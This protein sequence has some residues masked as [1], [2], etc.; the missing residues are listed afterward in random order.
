MGT[1]F[2]TTGDM[3]LKSQPNREQPELLDALSKYGPKQQQASNLIVVSHPT[4]NQNVRQ[5]LR[6]LH[7]AGLLGEFHTSL[8]WNPEWPVNLILP[9]RLRSELNRRSYPH[10]PQERIIVRPLRESLRLLAGKLGVRELGGFSTPQVAYSLDRATAEAIRRTKPGAVYAYEGVA[11]ESF[12]EAKRQSAVCFYELPSGYWYYERDLLREEAELQ[13]DYA[14]TI[15]K[16]KDSQEHLEKK[17]EELATADHV[18]IPSSHIARTLQNAPIPKSRLHVVPYGCDE[19]GAPIRPAG[20]SKGSKLR[21]LFVGSLTQRKGLSYAIDAIKQLG[22]RVEFTLIGA[23]VGES[24]TLDR[25]LSEHRWIRSLPHE[26]VL[27]EMANS[28]VLL[29]PSLSEGFGLVISEALSRGVPVIATRNTGGEE[30][31]RDGCNGFLVATRSSEEIAARLEQ[32]DQDRDQLE[33][34]A[35]EALRR[36]RVMNWKRYRDLLASIITPLLR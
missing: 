34:M 31:I 18:F 11:L 9:D 33:E 36:S 1:L 17:D 24:R 28:D 16:L 7:E 25:A 26:G 14:D 21:L 32:L 5:V 29:L 30:V 4:G 15:P 3:Q 19:S 20:R 6:A 13:P 12:R 10:V 27:K 2:T 23:R 8:R 22:P 35:S